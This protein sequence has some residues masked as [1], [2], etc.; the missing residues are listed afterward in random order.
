VLVGYNARINTL[1]LSRL[2]EEL[3]GMIKNFKLE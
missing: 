1:E 3:N 2:A